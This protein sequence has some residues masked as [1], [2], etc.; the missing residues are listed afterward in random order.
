MEAGI[1]ENRL[2]Y[3]LWNFFAFVAHVCCK[4][5]LALMVETFSASCVV[6]YFRL[7]TF[8]WH[9]PWRIPLWNNERKL[10]SQV[11]SFNFAV[12]QES[13]IHMYMYINIYIHF[14]DSSFIEF[15]GRNL[16]FG[17]NQVQLASLLV[18]QVG[19]CLGSCLTTFARCRTN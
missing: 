19:V 2:R 3:N 8:T 11:W 18:F 16:T 4:L 13:G 9:Q 14:S 5:L 17:D 10:I 15:A 7:R 12:R 6:N 1:D